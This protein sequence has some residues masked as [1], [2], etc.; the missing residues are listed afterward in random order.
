MCSKEEGALRGE[1]QEHHCQG[2]PNVL[3]RI[4]FHAQFQG[5]NRAPLLEELNKCASVGPRKAGTMTS[6]KRGPQWRREAIKQEGSTQVIC[7]PSVRIAWDRLYISPIMKGRLCLLPLITAAVYSV[8]CKVCALFKVVFLCY[9]A[10][11][12]E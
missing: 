7:L 6:I 4:W 9:S 3:K 8:G 1:E 11:G 12:T 5:Q 2:F 10:H